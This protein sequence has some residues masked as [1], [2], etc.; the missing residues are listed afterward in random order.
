VDKQDIVSKV[1]LKFGMLG[2]AHDPI[3]ANTKSRLLRR[4]WNED[5]PRN[6]LKVMQQLFV[7]RSPSKESKQDLFK[8][9]KLKGLFKRSLRHKDMEKAWRLLLREHDLRSFS[10]EN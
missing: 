7:D 1:L 4:F 5:E 8:F 9:F 2:E 10:L 6:V 3:D